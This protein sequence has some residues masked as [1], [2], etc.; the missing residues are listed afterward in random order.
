[1]LPR[2]EAERQALDDTV[3]HWLV[4]HPP[5]ANSEDDGCLHCGAALGDDGVPVLA[6]GAHT[7][8]HSACHPPWLAERRRHATEALSAMGIRT[9][10]R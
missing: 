6:G 10:R 3:N 1:M 7:W 9:M 4:M 2:P 5:P 8:L